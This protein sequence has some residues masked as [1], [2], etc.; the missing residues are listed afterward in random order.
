MKLITEN[1]FKVY[2]DKIKRGNV[3]GMNNDGTNRKGTWRF[4][5]DYDNCNKFIKVKWGGG[6]GCITAETGQVS[7]I[8]NESWYCDKHAVVQRL[9]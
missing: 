8:R 4:Y 7:D 1:G 5:C 6:Y 2:E 9:E 3:S